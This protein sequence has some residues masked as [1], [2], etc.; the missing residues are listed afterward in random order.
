MLL[1]VLGVGVLR[2]DALGRLWESGGLR[3][4][5]TI[6]CRRGWNTERMLGVR[7]TAVGMLLAFLML[8]WKKSF[9]S[10]THTS[11]CR[12]PSVA[13][14]ERNFSSSK[15]GSSVRRNCRSQGR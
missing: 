3:R 1:L 13:M 11:V 6:R 7:R 2:R 5:F 8:W 9:Q 14:T 12:T 10:L 4:R 15:S